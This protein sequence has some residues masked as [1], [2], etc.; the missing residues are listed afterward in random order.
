MKPNQAVGVAV[1]GAGRIGRHRARPAAAHTRHDQTR[2][3]S[4]HEEHE[5]HEEPEEHER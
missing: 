4:A 2:T 5:A 1:I 3:V